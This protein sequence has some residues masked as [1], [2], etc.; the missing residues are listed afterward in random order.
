MRCPSGLHTWATFVPMYVNDISNASSF[1]HFVLFAD[2]TNVICSHENF[3]DLLCKTNEELS[4]VT[5]WFTANRLIV[6]PDKTKVLYFGKLNT[7]R[8]LSDVIIKM[9]GKPLKVSN[10]VKFL[11]IELDD[12]LSFSSHL[13]NVCIKIAK[14][15]GILCKLRHILPEKYLFMLYNSSIVPF[16][17]YC[18]ITWASV[19]KSL[20]EPVFKLQKKALRICTNSHFLAPSGPLFSRLETLSVYDI[21]N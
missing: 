21:H 3:E 6:N 17:Y 7:S 12:K 20:L 18:N 8:K 15:I 5:D 16:I 10:N 4:K 2:N 1:F 11:G 13:K 9:N 19:G 14:N